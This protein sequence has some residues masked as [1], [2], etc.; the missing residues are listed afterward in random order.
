MA[1][2]RPLLGFVAFVATFF[3]WFYGYTNVN[4]VQISSA[5]G[6]ARSRRFLVPALPSETTLGEQK[7]I[8]KQ[9]NLHKNESQTKVN[10]RHFMIDTVH[11]VAYCR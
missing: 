4:F 8:L 6:A 1:E 2:I 11:K 9:C 7:Y 3:I 5:S 10:P